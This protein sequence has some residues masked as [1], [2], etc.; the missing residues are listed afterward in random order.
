[1]YVKSSA[2][3]RI[4]PSYCASCQSGSYECAR[5]KS[6]KVLVNEA[7]IAWMSVWFISFGIN[8]TVAALSIASSIFFSC[9]FPRSSASIS[10]GAQHPSPC[11]SRPLLPWASS[12]RKHHPLTS[13]A[14]QPGCYGTIWIS[15]YWSS[16]ESTSISILGFSF[17]STLLLFA[18]SLISLASA[19]IKIWLYDLSVSFLPLFSIVFLSS[20]SV[21]S[22]L[23]SCLMLSISSAPLLQYLLYLMLSFLAL[24]LALL[25][26]LIFSSTRLAL[27]FLQKINLPCP[28]FLQE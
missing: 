12:S 10:D 5:S 3:Y 24:M 27:S 13:W 11:F 22:P 8:L 7:H 17:A 9:H 18:S 1:M 19:P 26:L 16:S 14:C 23:F 15:H 2:N 4:S 20:K 6:Y 25:H 21:L 28:T